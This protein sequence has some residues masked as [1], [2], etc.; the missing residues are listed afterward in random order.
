[1]KKSLL[2]QVHKLRDIQPDK[3]WKA[4]SQEFLR[5]QISD[6]VK[7]GA[8]FKVMVWIKDF[9]KVSSQPAFALAAFILILITGTVFF[10]PMLSDAKPNDSLYI[11]RIISEKAQVNMTFNKENRDR[12]S[13]QFATN[14]AKDITNLIND[15]NFQSNEDSKDKIADLSND[16]NKEINSAR[17]SIN[18]INRRDELASERRNNNS[19][20]N[21]DEN[22][23]LE[24]DSDSSE[25]LPV[26]DEGAVISADT[27]KDDQGLEINIKNNNDKGV[28]VLNSDEELPVETEEVDEDKEVANEEVEDNEN[29][30]SA[31]ETK[32][33]DEEEN[34]SSTLNQLQSMTEEV[35][36]EGGDVDETSKALD[37]AQ[38]LFNEE[39]Y[40]EALEK[41]NEVEGMLEGVSSEIS[42]DS[43][44]E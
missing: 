35:D 22:N 13:A 4:E 9:A 40:Q 29:S 25:D 17:E 36:K 10:N 14:H 26:D 23:D 39:K 6:D 30:D 18:N 15:P 1:M 38:R 32:G 33:S 34:A 24:A 8:F 42:D 12:L 19:N 7:T 11:A 20:N 41:L 21:S 2:T 16:F 28:D 31:D 43:S 44:L 37:D 5:A 3:Q 27:R